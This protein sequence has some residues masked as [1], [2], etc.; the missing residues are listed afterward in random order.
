MKSNTTEKQVINVSFNY[1][2]EGASSKN[3]FSCCP[4][5]KKTIKTGVPLPTGHLKQ[6]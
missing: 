1:F 6:K 2:F 4:P 3:S 5:A